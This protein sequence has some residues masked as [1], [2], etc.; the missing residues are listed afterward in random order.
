MTNINLIR[1]L[2]LF[3]SLLINVYPVLFMVISGNMISQL[4]TTEALNGPT[5]A[6]GGRTL[7]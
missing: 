6:I 4:S 7:R 1:V 2:L 5:M 3:L